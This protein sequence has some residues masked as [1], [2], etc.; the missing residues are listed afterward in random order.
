MQIKWSIYSSVTGTLHTTYCKDTETT[1][2]T[3]IVHRPHQNIHDEYVYGSHPCSQGCMATIKL[4]SWCMHSITTHLKWLSDEKS[5]E[6]SKVHQPTSLFFEIACAVGR[7]KNDTW[8]N[9]NRICDLQLMLTKLGTEKLNWKDV[10][11]CPHQLVLAAILLF[12][13]HCTKYSNFFFFFYS[14]FFHIP[15][16]STR[17]P[18][19]TGLWVTW[20]RLLLEVIHCHYNCACFGIWWKC[21]MPV[22]RSCP[23]LVLYNLQIIVT[24]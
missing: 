6:E 22:H 21:D 16:Y 18:R 12:G 24:C 20:L 9:S 19:T 8:H 14:S 15:A 23:G 7:Y 4:Y 3:C 11:S 13:L 1:P 10:S 17:Q 5:K 2:P